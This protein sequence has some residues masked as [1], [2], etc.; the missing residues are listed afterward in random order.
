MNVLEAIR[1][2]RAVRDFADRLVPEETI[3][4]IVDAGRH[5]Q[6]SKNEQAWHF[7][8]IRDRE[9][10]RQLST[11]GKYAATSPAQRSAWRWCRRPT[12]ASTWGR[13]PRICSSRPGSWA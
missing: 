6:S 8:V 9:T 5:A 10:L 11:C 13:P 3:R 2:K 4:Q 12:P 7:I 1:T